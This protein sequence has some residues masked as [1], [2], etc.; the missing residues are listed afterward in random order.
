VEKFDFNFP[1]STAERTGLTRFTG[2]VGTGS[3]EILKF[4]WNRWNSFDVARVYIMEHLRSPRNR[5][6]IWP[7]TVYRSPFPY[8]LPNGLGP[9]AGRMSKIRLRRIERRSRRQGA[10]TQHVL[11]PLCGETGFRSAEAHLLTVGKEYPRAR[12]FAIWKLDCWD[13]LFGKATRESCVRI[14]FTLWQ[15]CGHPAG[16]CFRE[17][18]G[19][20]DTPIAA[21]VRLVRLRSLGI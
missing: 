19:F 4:I 5:R 9:P 15:R 11:R 3:K 1:I 14:C 20:R 12:Y 10:C 13:C 6:P 7:L 17:N 21:F 2:L 18:G 8:G 16:W